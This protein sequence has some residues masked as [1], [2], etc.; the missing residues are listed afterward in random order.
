MDWL[1]REYVQQQAGKNLHAALDVTIEHWTQLYEATQTELLTMQESMISSRFC[2]LCT[3]F[4]TE[5]TDFT[6]DACLL[7]KIG[8][9][10]GDPNSLWFQAYHA[11]TDL[12]LRDGTLES[13]RKKAK[14][15]LK[16]LKS[17]KKR[18]NKSLWYNYTR[19]EHFCILCGYEN[20]CSK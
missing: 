17:L 3:F 12:V 18:K 6:C 4:R 11:L 19:A 14:K 9:V 20:R 1:T 8:H 15:L 16:V 10:C 13:F 5:E 2:G 7:N